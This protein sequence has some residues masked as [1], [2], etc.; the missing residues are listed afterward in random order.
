MRYL[1]LFLGRKCCDSSGLSQHRLVEIRSRS[2][3]HS[4]MA[5]TGAWQRPQ[6][7]GS[8][9]IKPQERLVSCELCALTEKFPSKNPFLNVS[10]D[11]SQIGEFKYC[12]NI[13]EV[14]IILSLPLLLTTTKKSLEVLKFTGSW[15]TD[16]K[17]KERLNSSIYPGDR[18]PGATEYTNLLY[19]WTSQPSD[20]CRQRR[21]CYISA[22]KQQRTL[23]SCAAILVFICHGTC[24]STVCL[25]LYFMNKNPII[26]D[27]SKILWE[28]K[29]F[30]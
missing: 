8:P 28:Y 20:L 14:F 29:K 9:W 24:Q 12:S 21:N 30:R 15:L 3:P 1:L 7:L 5:P 17:R 23:A 4:H 19:S 25:L 10:C 27:M 2:P 6:I 22:H 16:K 26:S 13:N 11:F 18:R